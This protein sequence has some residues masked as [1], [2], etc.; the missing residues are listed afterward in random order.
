MSLEK[1]YKILGLSKNANSSEMKTA[2]EKLGFKYHPDWAK[3]SGL[4]L[5]EAETKFRNVMEAYTALSDMKSEK[6]R[7]QT[8]SDFKRPIRD[9]SGDIFLNHSGSGQHFRY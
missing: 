8:R 1:Y 4:D 9:F 3:I 2:F 7:I 5:S 6:Q